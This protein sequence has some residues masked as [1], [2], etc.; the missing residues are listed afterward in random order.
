MADGFSA[1]WNF[2]NCVGAIDG[3]HV[4]IVKPPNSGSFYYNYKGDFSVVLMAVVNANYEFIM[5]DCGI[6][7]R[8]SDGGVIAYTP[9]GHKLAE[10]TLGLPDREKLSGC[11]LKL[12]FVFV[13][14]DAFT[15]SENL[16]KPYKGSK[17]TRHQRIFN[18]RCSRAR[19]VSE[20][21]FGIIASRFRI[22]HK[23]IYLSPTKTRKIVLACT[24][25]HNYIRKH[26]STNYIPS[27]SVDVENIQT[28]ETI[29][30]TWRKEGFIVHPL[31]ISK[32]NRATLAAEAVRDDFKEYFNGI[33]SVAW[34]DKSIAL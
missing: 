34:Q 31:K 24:Y 10:G 3:K 5:A 16:L 33:G 18:Y 27:G 17:L 29:Q 30:G 23:P 21:A 20:N 4:S 14:D 2:P 25:L 9:F 22:F 19:G 12:P 7:G 13:A 8:V 11:Q 1:R 28:G 32:K 15:L 26:R 6:N